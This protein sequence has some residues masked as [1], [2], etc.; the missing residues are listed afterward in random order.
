[1]ASKQRKP[2]SPP[3]WFRLILDRSGTWFTQN[4]I[5]N[6]YDLKIDTVRIAFKRHE[7]EG[8][9]FRNDRNL[10]QLRYC[11]ADVQSMIRNKFQEYETQ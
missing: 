3:K 11:L 5:A 1:M 9:P 2:K 6:D 10:I 4:D 8:E 7:I